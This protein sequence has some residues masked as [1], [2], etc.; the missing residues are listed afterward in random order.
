MIDFMKFKYVY[1][2]RYCQWLGTVQLGGARS[3]PVR[4]IFTGDGL[5]PAPGPTCG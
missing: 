5:P 3:K 1:Y 4:V 2:Y